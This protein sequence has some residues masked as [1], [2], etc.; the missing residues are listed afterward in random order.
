MYIVK[1][2]PISV[3]RSGSAS[4]ALLTPLR[5]P[6]KPIPRPGPGQGLVG[7]HVD[8]V[9][10]RTLLPVH[11]DGDEMFIQEPGDL[12]VFERLLLHDVAPVAGGGTQSVQARA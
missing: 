11:L 10:V 12:L 5:R 8:G 6:R 9:H 2:R 7:F 3:T 1:L 4:Y